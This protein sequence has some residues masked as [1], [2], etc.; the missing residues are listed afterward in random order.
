MTRIQFL[1]VYH[2]PIGWRVFFR[3]KNGI[4]LHAWPRGPALHVWSLRHPPSADRRDGK[5][6]VQWPTSVLTS[7]KAEALPPHQPNVM[8]TLKDKE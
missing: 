5:D 3:F 8:P 1:P 4:T 6:S 2:P 7:A